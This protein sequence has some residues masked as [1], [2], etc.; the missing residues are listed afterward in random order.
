MFYNG[1]MPQISRTPHRWRTFSAYLR[2][3]FGERVY[4]SVIPERAAV[5]E[6][7]AAHEP[8]V[9]Y[10][11]ASPVAEAFRTLAEEVEE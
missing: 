2:E 9:T 11:P 6:A 5:V 8:V 1:V 10:A 7:S 4:R 3:R